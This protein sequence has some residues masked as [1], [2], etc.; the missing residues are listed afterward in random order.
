MGRFF[1]ER[2]TFAHA[3]G[4]CLLW[5]QQGRGGQALHMRRRSLCYRLERIAKLFDVDLNNP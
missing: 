4:A 5:G 3:G 1:E 2:P